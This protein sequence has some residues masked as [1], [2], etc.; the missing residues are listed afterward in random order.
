MGGSVGERAARTDRK[1]LG[2]K[3]FEGHQGVARNR[4]FNPA[5]DTSEMDCFGAI[6]DAWAR[7]LQFGRGIGTEV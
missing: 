1:H 3:Y 2:P 6:A 7:V 5:R 4:S